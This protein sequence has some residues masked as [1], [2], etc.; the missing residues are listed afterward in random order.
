MEFGFLNL[1]D[2][3]GLATFGSAIC[4][5]SIQPFAVNQFAIDRA[6]LTLA[7][8]S[9][10]ETREL[11]A[12]KAAGNALIGGGPALLCVVIALALFPAGPAALWLG[13]LLGLL[14]TY[15]L[16]APAAAALSAVFPR[17]VDLNSIG[18]SSNAHG[19]AGLLGVLAFVAAG[20]PPVV[21]ALIATSLMGRP[22]LVPILIAC[23][24]GIALAANRVLF[25]AVAVLFEK[26]KENLGLVVK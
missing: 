16:A 8:L 15:L 21:L 4:L 11:L 2:G 18:R 17:A 19:A 9:P 22:N 1:S 24:C 14:A 10:L 5:L 20:L 6:G 3:L 12:G 13:L 7:L 25:R 23:W 26:R